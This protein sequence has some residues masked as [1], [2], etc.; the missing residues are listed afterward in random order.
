[1]AKYELVENNHYMYTNLW[2][3]AKA[4]GVSPNAVFKWLWNWKAV[5]FRVI[6]DEKEK[7][8]Y[9]AVD[10]FCLMKQE[11]NHLWKAV[12]YKERWQRKRSI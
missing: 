9:M 5:K 11:I 7:R 2:T 1:M 6:V 4:Y 10:D 3:F 8:F 12:K